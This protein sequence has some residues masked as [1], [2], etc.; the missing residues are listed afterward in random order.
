MGDEISA[1][2][3]DLID[4]Y[5]MSLHVNQFMFVNIIQGSEPDQFTSLKTT[6]SGCIGRYTGATFYCFSHRFRPINMQTTTETILKFGP[7]N[8]LHGQSDDV[9]HSLAL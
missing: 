4:S 6:L 9:R 1:K 8:T 7:R 5:N 2:D 3:E